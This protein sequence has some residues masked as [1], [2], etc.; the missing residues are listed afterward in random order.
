MKQLFLFGAGASAGSG[1]CHPEVPVVGAKLIRVLLPFLRVRTLID[2]DLIRL[3]E[4]NFELGMHEF[5]TRHPDAMQHFIRDMAYYF[6]RFSPEPGNHYIELVRTIKTKHHD[7]LL[8]TLNYE[9][10]I[11]AAI[12]MCG[13]TVA[14]E[15]HGSR[16][17]GD[18]TL[19]KLHG[20]CNF[21]PD[22]GGGSI[23]GISLAIGPPDP[24]YRSMA[25]AAYSKP[26]RDMNKVRKFLQ[27][28]D[29]LAPEMAVY[30]KE[31]TILF[32]DYRNGQRWQAEWRS[33]LAD[34]DQ[35][36]VIGTRLVEHDTHIWDAVKTFSG[37]VCWVSP[38]PDA[39]QIWCSR[40]GVRFEHTASTFEQF[41]PI[42][43]SRY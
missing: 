13:S 3:F 22:L 21:L 28:E 37:T 6:S 20:S 38:N 36:F 11:E 16:S 15:G 39:A 26:E 17:T 12:T 9:M 33:F 7:V 24:A 43:R 4:T 31:K 29:V 30:H 27:E 35:I 1:P 18:F 10:L 2:V 40:H 42:Y 25:V 19:L 34:A 41:V 32:G 14:Y 23:S 5:W 8:S